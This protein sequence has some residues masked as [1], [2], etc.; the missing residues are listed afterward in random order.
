[1][2]G[3]YA[4]PSLNTSYRQI[5]RLAGDIDVI[6]EDSIL[7]IHVDGIYDNSVLDIDGIYDS[8]VT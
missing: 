1:M 2:Q 3:A 7:D 4:R 5:L 8:S 6:Y